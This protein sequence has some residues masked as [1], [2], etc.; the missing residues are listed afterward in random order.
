MVNCRNLLYKCV[1][2]SKYV[3]TQLEVIFI[4][5]PLLSRWSPSSHGQ[6][7]KRSKRQIFRTSF[8]ATYLQEDKAQRA[9]MFK[10]NAI[11][12]WRHTAQ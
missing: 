10:L 7:V 5:L 8:F 2:V 6:K 1:L 4:P 3:G 11:V 9:H 12:A